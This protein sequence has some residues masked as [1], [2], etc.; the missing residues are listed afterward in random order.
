VLPASKKMALW[1]V[2]RI[3]CGPME[4][5]AVV[6]PSKLE[7]HDSMARK[8]SSGSDVEPSRIEL[9]EPTMAKKNSSG[10]DATGGPES[11]DDDLEWVPSGPASPQATVRRMFKASTAKFDSG[12][13]AEL[14]AEDSSE[15]DSDEASPSGSS[16]VRVAATTESSRSDESLHMSA[17]MPRVQVRIHSFWRDVAVSEAQEIG[18]HLARG[19][20]RFHLNARGCDYDIDFSHVGRATQTNM[21]SG[22][23]RKLRILVSNQNSRWQSQKRLVQNQPDPVEQHRLGPQSLRGYAPQNSLRLLGDNCH[24]HACFR[25]FKDRERKYCGEWAVFY[26]SYSHAALIYEVQA[27]IAS[28]LF[29]FQAQYA[30]LPRLLMHDFYDIP[31]AGMLLHRF[32]SD[33]VENKRD[34]NAAFRKVALSTMCSLTAKGP[35]MCLAKVFTSGYSCKDVRFRSLLESLLEACCIPHDRAA[36]LT[37]AIVALAE[38]HGLDTSQFGGKACESGKAGHAVQI[39]VRRS[40]VDRLSYA[41][42]P[43][44]YVDEERMPLSEWLNGDNPNTYGQAR[45]VAHPEH[46]M[47]AGHVRMYVASADPTFHRKRVDFQRELCALI[48][49][50]QEPKQRERAATGIYGG[51]LPPW[52]AASERARNVGKARSRAATA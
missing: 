40:L 36:S 18:E 48:K 30:P 12:F 14:P 41:A 9:Q 23:T 45:V 34:H 44:G 16:R 25:Y 29:G 51:V 35:E 8:V 37:D 42:K 46:F 32:N 52:W 38:K 11:E 43:Y 3:G 17:P 26:H 15:E 13:L 4:R 47:Q 21:T 5:N 33:F 22:K 50:L 2:R 20:A 1:L 6:E 19:E 24:A 49:E 10:S 31:N 27:A 28:A 7:L 39:F